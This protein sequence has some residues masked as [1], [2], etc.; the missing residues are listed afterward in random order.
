IE[1]DGPLV[2]RQ[3]YY[4]IRLRLWLNRGD[5]I[6]WDAP[7]G[8]IDRARLVEDGHVLETDVRLNR[9]WL[10]NGLFYGA[11][12][13]RVGGKRKLRISPHLGY[14]KQGVPGVIPENA[15]LTAELVFLNEVQHQE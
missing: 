6:K 4:R 13:M 8:L 3:H 1:G 12:G 10:I 5:A 7:W 11:E 2:E 9:E 14:G 15:V